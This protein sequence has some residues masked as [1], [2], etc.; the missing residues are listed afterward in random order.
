MIAYG[1]WDII[2]QIEFMSQNFSQQERPWHKLVIVVDSIERLRLFLTLL[3][4]REPR[5]MSHPTWNYILFSPS[6]NYSGFCGRS[7][8]FPNINYYALS[9]I[10]RQLKWMWSLT[11]QDIPC[12]ESGELSSKRQLYKLEKAKAASIRGK[13]RQKVI[14][15][16]CRA[17]PTTVRSKQYY[18]M[19]RKKYHPPMGKWVVPKLF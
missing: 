10:L 11:Y 15:K 8:A 13:G 16:S 19:A 4:A 14:R 7:L 1:V 12:L 3:E 17:K 5:I 9:Y 2:K 18:S 6:E